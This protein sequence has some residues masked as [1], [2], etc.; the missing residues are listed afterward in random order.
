MKKAIQYTDL[1]IKD[2]KNIRVIP[3]LSISKEVLEDY[4]SEHK[5]NCT[6]EEI[7][8]YYDNFQLLL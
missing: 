3:E 1:S 2:P 5:L 6:K 7:K 4:S 8:K